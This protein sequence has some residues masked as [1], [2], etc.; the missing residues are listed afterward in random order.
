MQRNQRNAPNY[1]FR[2]S[3]LAGILALVVALLAL[4]GYGLEESL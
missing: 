2:A 1:L 3:A 4:T